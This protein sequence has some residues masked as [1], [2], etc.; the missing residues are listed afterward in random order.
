[1]ES[2]YFVELMLWFLAPIAIMLVLA[3]ISLV[4]Y[5]Y[6][7]SERRHGKNLPHKAQNTFNLWN[8]FVKLCLWVCL[9]FYPQLSYV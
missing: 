6:F 7:L 3:L 9:V 1:M 4:V 8:L 5:F 2:Y